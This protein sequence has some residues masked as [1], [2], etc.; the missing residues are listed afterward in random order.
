MQS[1]KIKFLPQNLEVFVPAGTSVVE[2]ADLARVDIEPTPCGRRGTCGKC[3]ILC[4]DYSG[5]PTIVEKEKIIAAKLDQ[6]WRLACQTLI[7]QDMVI[8][9]PGQSAGK[10]I[11]ALLSRP[12]SVIEIQPTIIKHFLKVPPPTMTDQRADWDR[13]AELLLDPQQEL[14]L[15]LLRKLPELMRKNNF[16]ITVV[17][18]RG[19][20][21]SV[22]AGDTTTVGYGCAI[23]IGTT[24]VICSL[25]DLFNGQEI[26]AASAFN[27]QR[28]YGADVLSRIDFSL[29]G[30]NLKKL[31]NL[32]IDQ[33]NVLIEEVISQA[34]INRSDIYL[35]SVVGNTTMQ[36][37]FLG[38][39]S[40][41]IATPPFVG[42]LYTGLSF[43]STDLGI[44][45]N[46]RGKVAFLPN[47]A[48][49]VGAD[50]VAGVLAT[51]AYKY[52]APCVLIDV[53]T[54]AEIVLAAQGSL[55]ACSAAA[56]PAFEGANICYG[57][58]AE[59][60]AIDRVWLEDG[61]LHYH[62][63]GE[64]PALGLCGS[65]LVDVIAELLSIGIIDFSGRLLTREEAIPIVGDTLAES[66]REN[67][68]G[69]EFVIVE[70]S[71]FQKVS[72]TQRD[73]RQVQLAKG[74]ILAGIRIMIKEMGIKIEDIELFNLAGSFGNVLNKKNAQVVG[75]IPAT[76]SLSKVEY[77]GNSAH[78]GAQINLLRAD[79]EEIVNSVVKNIKYIELSD[80]SDFTEEF[81]NAMFFGECEG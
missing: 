54:N 33:V 55:Y 15:T 46:D 57:M 5:I 52:D 2:A 3:L 38:L 59:T 12:K 23:D 14:D 71:E 22:E 32:I 6:G 79:T 51:G 9:V 48:G 80:R 68:D 76:I 63:I 4:H 41:Y 69:D 72:L 43:D 64:V 18:Y 61:K 62:V 56:G 8:E 47:V 27:P 10:L 24:T 21:I 25:H 39:P 50:I 35:L 78:V 37:L 58:R 36:H 70:N 19:K 77:A 81:T 29:T 11:K 1:F 42:T 45:I 26:T 73:I 13:V 7:V 44:K 53:G 67:D 20:V 30:N 17:T 28:T 65:G 75:L 60:G 40:R 34:G 66:L 49:Y 31:Q 74:A 16:E